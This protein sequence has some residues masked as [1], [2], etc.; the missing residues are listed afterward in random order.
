MSEDLVSDLQ[1]VLEGVTQQKDQAYSERNKILAAFAWHL[2]QF[3]NVIVGRAK[4]PAE[5]K[6]WEDY[7]RNIII[8]IGDGNQMTWHIHD[9]ELHMFEKLPLLHDYKWDGHTTEPSRNM[10][11]Y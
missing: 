5:D 6:S 10:K 2:Y 4:H 3:S 9:S 8:I 11:D 1:Y 7:W